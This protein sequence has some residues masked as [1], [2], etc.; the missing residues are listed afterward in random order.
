MKCTPAHDF[1]DYKLA[2]K[3][4]I[5]NYIS[6]FNLDGT[7]NENGMD[8]KSMDRFV[9]RKKVIELLK[10]S[11]HFLKEEECESEI[12][13]SERTDT[14]V[15]PMMSLQWFVKMQPITKKTIHLLTKQKPNF[16]PKRF[17]K[18]LIR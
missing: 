16:L 6:V 2:K 4:N 9:A 14:I 17:E 3:H 1:N 13:Y 7:L 8:C 15:E 5:T 10:H 18:T 12:G 11:K